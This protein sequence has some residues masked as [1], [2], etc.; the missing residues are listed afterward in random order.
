MSHGIK[1]HSHN[2]GISRIRKYYDKECKE[3]AKEYEKE[4]E[5]IRNDNNV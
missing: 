1:N 2:K 5:K 3:I 4:L